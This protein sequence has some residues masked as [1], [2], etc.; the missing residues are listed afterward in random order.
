[1]HRVHVVAAAERARRVGRPLVQVAHHVERA[2]GGD[3]ARARAGEVD[4]LGEL[5]DAGVV[6]VE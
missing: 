5:V 3:A 1:M 6:D 2:L 4:R